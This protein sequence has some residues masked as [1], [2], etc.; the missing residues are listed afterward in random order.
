VVEAD[1]KRLQPF[2]G[3]ARLEVALLRKEDPDKIIQRQVIDEVSVK[4]GVEEV[5]LPCREID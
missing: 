1:Y 2:D 3:N 5:T 4:A